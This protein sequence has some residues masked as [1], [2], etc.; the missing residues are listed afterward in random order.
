MLQLPKSL[1]K[2]AHTHTM[3][4]VPCECFIMECI[5]DE[6]HVSVGTER[7]GECMCVQVMRWSLNRTNSA[8]A[9]I[10]RNWTSYDQ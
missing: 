1:A 6:L 10:Q 3:L 9:G 2:S 7:N 4:C 8:K 5:Y